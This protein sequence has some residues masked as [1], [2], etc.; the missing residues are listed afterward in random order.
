ML[1]SSDAEGGYVLSLPLS[2]D[3][4]RYPAFMNSAPLTCEANVLRLLGFPFLS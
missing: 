1:G 4:V 3:D 2:G